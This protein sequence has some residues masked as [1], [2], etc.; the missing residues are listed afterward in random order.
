M[1]ELFEG[2]P[3][4]NP[5]I[6]SDDFKKNIRLF[7]ADI[8]GQYYLNHNKIQLIPLKNNGWVINPKKR[9]VKSK[10]LLT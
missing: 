4:T 10:A 2:L 1:K 7:L 5:V 8:G 6:S 9:L 3:P